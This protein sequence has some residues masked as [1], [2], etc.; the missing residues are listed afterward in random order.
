[1]KQQNHYSAL[2]PRYITIKEAALY[3]SIGESTLRRH[4]AEGIIPTYKVG[5]SHRIDVIELDNRL[6]S[7]KL[8]LN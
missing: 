8:E 3:L 4:I 5:G 6:H 2:T 1:M 7:G